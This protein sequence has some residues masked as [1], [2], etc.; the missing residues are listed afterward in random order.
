[1]TLPG[2]GEMRQIVSDRATCMKQP[3]GAESFRLVAHRAAASADQSRAPAPGV[4]PADH[5]R[6]A[7]AQPLESG[8][9]AR[10]QVRARDE[11]DRGDRARLEAPGR[12]LHPAASGHA[13]APRLSRALPPI[14]N[15]PA[16]DIQ[17]LAREA[18]GAETNP[19]PCRL[20]HREIRRVL[21]HEKGSQRWLRLGRRNRAVGRGRLHRAR[22]ALR[23]DGPRRRACRPAACSGS[24][25]SR[26][27]RRSQPSPTRSTRR[28]AFS[29]STCGP[30]PDIGHDRWV[31]MDAALGQFDVG[32]IAIFK[33]ALAE[34]DPMVDLNMPILTLMQNLHVT[35]LKT[36][37]RRVQFLRPDVA[38]ALPPPIS[39]RRALQ[40]PCP[41]FQ[42]PR[43]RPHRRSPPCRPDID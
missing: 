6:P 12:R 37:A 32:H 10:A 30:R 42:R 31:A 26:P 19:C 20:S 8:R 3:E 18:V 15:R 21:H 38:P 14:W 2:L 16:P 40:R 7:K 11:R 34:I 13:R 4:L 23:R 28:P 33:S 24:A 27:A 29:A 17:R 39:C 9:A 22:R 25:T 41:P 35:V 1:M 36:V 43:S 5:R